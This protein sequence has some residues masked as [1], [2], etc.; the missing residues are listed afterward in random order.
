MYYPISSLHWKVTGHWLVILL[1]PIDLQLC[2]SWVTRR[3]CT[4]GAIKLPLF[5][6]V[7]FQTSAM[8]RLQSRNASVARREHPPDVLTH[9]LTLGFSVTTVLVGFCAKWRNVNPNS[10]APCYHDPE[11]T[12]HNPTFKETSS[13]KVSSSFDSENFSQEETK[14][15]TRCLQV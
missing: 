15:A 11:I 1:F 4:V 2:P 6:T 9:A 13:L 5:M 12:I 3:Q 8:N 10:H 14:E 7:L